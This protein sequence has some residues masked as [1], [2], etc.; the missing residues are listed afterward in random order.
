MLPD[1]HVPEHDRL[2]LACALKI[3]KWLQPHRI[4]STGDAM[5]A[6]PWSRHPRKTMPSE[7]RSL[8]RTTELEPMARLIRYLK[9][10]A[11]DEYIYVFGNHEHRV[12][13]WCA[14]HA[15]GAD[16]YDAL[17]PSAWFS[18]ICQVVP[19]QAEPTL[20]HFAMRDDLWV[21]HGWATGE[22]QGKKHLQRV[23]DVSL[24]HGHGHHLYWYSDRVPCSGGV[25]QRHSI[26][27]GCLRTLAPA[28]LGSR[29]QPWS[30][31]V[32]IVFHG[33]H[34]WTPCLVPINDG[35]AHIEGKT[36]RATEEDCEELDE[37]LG[38]AANDHQYASEAA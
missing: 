25:R 9:R 11:T 23:G 3:A 8:F 17:S 21:V 4:I 35:V 31:G 30:H 29:P 5:E 26:S 24:I 1:I 18:G 7:L 15:M 14:N 27:P 22:N 37:I 28:W 20:S 19:Y 33:A 36:I 32:V 12:E 2:A 10:E 34:S 38:I 13:S 6:A 16:V